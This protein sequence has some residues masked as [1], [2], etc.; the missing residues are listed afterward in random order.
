M[1]LTDLPTLLRSLAPVLRDGEW[2][3]CWLDH[4]AAQAHAE[5][6]L[7]SMREDDGMSLVLPLAHARAHGLPDTPAFRCITLTVHSSLEAV[8]LTAAVS[9]ALAAR[10][11]AAN[12][13]A[14][15]RHDHVFVPEMRADEALAVLQ[16][17]S[18]GA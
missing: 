14:G 1:H 13:I 5:H 11:I 10:G 18:R 12:V 15:A 7:A 2:V 17:L 8:G 16:A 3:F 6:A 9:G 4:D